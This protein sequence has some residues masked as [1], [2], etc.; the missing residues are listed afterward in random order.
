MDKQ[1]LIIE[2]PELDDK[3][4]VDLQQFLQ[5]L[6]NAFENHYLRQ[7]KRYYQ[8]LYREEADKDLF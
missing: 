5:D 4:A 7:I 2:M 3:A 6:T 1:M 8:K